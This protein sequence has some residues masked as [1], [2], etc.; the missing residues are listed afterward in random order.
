MQ[1]KCSFFLL[2]A[3]LMTSSTGFVISGTQ[4]PAPEPCLCHGSMIDCRN[5]GLDTIPIFKYINVDS[6]RTLDMGENRLAA[7][8]ASAFSELSLT[9][10]YLDNNNISKVHEMAF[11]GHEK[12]LVVLN[13]ANNNLQQL[14][15]AVG[16]LHVIKI[17]DISGNPIH[18]SLRIN[19][20]NKTVDGLTASV[21]NKIGG[22]IKEF[23]FG[24]RLTLRNWPISLRH[25][26]QLEI[27]KIIGSN[28]DLLYQGSFHGFTETL[29]SLTIEHSQLKQVPVAIGELQ[30]LEELHIDYSENDIG[31]KM[32]IKQPF[33]Q[34]SSSLK[35][36][37]L[38][39]NKLKHFPSVI[40]Y[41]IRLQVL[42][43][44]GNYFT[45]VSDESV[46]DLK[47]T[48]VS[49]LNLKNCNLKRIPSSISELKALTELDLSYNAIVTIEDGDIQHS[50]SLRNLSLKANPLK[51]IARTSFTGLDLLK[52]LDLS[53]TNMT[54][55]SEGVQNLYSLETLDLSNTPMECTCDM[56][57]VKRW[58]DIF[59]GS[60]RIHGVCDTIDSLIQEYLNN[61]VPKCPDYS[62]DEFKRENKHNEI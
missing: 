40:R 10:I 11:H 20:E 57:W 55:I 16:R 12:E 25:L 48:N 6:F 52:Y 27:L 26:Q 59:G 46:E 44:E 22:S 36:L 24:H 33:Q 56:F 60:L 4:C 50:F 47:K 61:R 39:Y 54:Y 32:I 2:L 43:L 23:S 41:L 49:I 53:N 14:P 30:H 62:T 29:K 15:I 37:S 13:L 21:M 5:K 38:K 1:W 31:D 51:Y 8:P 34:I 17:L 42:S 58:I 45:Y 19:F 35:V 18:S 3:F 9:A 7:L 28:I